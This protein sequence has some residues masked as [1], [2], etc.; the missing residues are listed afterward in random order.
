MPITHQALS[1]LDEQNRAIASD[2]T[3]YPDT[4]LG[5]AAFGDL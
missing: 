5:L 2:R 3:N 4:K 1:Y